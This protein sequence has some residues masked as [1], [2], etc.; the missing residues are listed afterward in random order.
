M[1]EKLRQNVVYDA[2]VLDALMPGEQ[3]KTLAFHARQLGIPV[4]MISG[5]PEKLEFAMTACKCSKSH[6]YTKNSQML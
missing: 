3:S 5:C 6:S 4:V 1:R 2:I